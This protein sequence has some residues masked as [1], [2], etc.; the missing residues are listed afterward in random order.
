MKSANLIIKISEQLKDS[1][2]DFTIEET[3]D[4]IIIR[5]RCFYSLEINV[6]LAIIHRTG[7]SFWFSSLNSEN[8]VELNISKS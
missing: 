4:L 2:Q 8:Q 7:K 3:E 5:K 6:V 1:Q